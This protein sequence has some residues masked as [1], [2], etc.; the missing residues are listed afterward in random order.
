M[1]ILCVADAA[2][3]KPEAMKKACEIFSGAQVVIETAE[4]NVRGNLRIMEKNGP[5]AVPVPEVMK[6]NTD[7]EII[8][9]GIV[10]PFSQ[11]IIEMF[12]KLRIIGLCR[13][14]LDNIDMDTVKERG[15]MV[16]N[17]IGRNAEAVSDFAVAL[18]LSEVRNI[19]R[20]HTLL[21]TVDGSW[22]EEFVSSSYVPHIKD[23][24]IGIFGFG[25]IGRLVCRKLTGFGCD[26]LVYDPYVPDETIKM[27]GYT[28]SDKEN[29]FKEA[30][31]ITLHARYGPETEAI[32]GKAEIRSMKPTAYLI[33]TARSGLIDMDELYNALAE[34]RIGGAALDV[35][36]DEPLPADSRWRKLDNCTITSH[37]AGSVLASRDYAAELVAQSIRKAIEGE[38][39]PQI[40]TREILEKESFKIWAVEAEKALK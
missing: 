35:F 22:A 1:K 30:D 26:I 4:E 12:P 31:V 15:I 29:L 38:I 9:G 27:S 28:P 10:C 19:A 40:I 36:P 5:D 14:G 17:G 13:A 39:V 3:I 32:V 16:V 7:A 24:K 37:M 8:I 6:Q 23:C 20:S 11:T 21:T 25:M 34:H 33:N 2:G 18:M